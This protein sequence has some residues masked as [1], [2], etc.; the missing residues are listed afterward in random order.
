M[1]VQ[2]LGYEAGEFREHFT[3]MLRHI[4]IKRGQDRIHAQSNHS[5]DNLS[6]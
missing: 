4:P 6:L 3:I 2:F 1:L 5:S